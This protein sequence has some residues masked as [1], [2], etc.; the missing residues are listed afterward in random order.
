M[1]F[2]QV[3]YFLALCDVLNFTRAAEKCNVS[4][5]SLTRAIQNLEC[6]LGGPL[7]HRERQRT[8]LTELGRMMRP[9][10][11]QVHIQTQQA[12]SLAVRFTKLD[13]IP[14][15]VGVMCTI[16]PTVF[17]EF[18]RSFR[19]RHP[20]IDIHFLDASGY[21]LADMLL[22]GDVEVALYG[23]PE[24]LDERLHGLSLFRERFV[25]AFPSGHRFEAMNAVCA[26]ELNGERYVSRANCEVYQHAT[27]IFRQRGISTEMVLRSPREDWVQA[28]VLAGMGFGFFPEFGVT[29]QGLLTRPL[30]DPEMYRTINLVTVRGRPYSPAVGAFVREAKAY[31]W[32]ASAGVDGSPRAVA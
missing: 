16:G 14:L 21:A 19:E 23:L 6:E 17:C 13:D 9:Y 30:I 25:I 15:K 27:E 22:K 26:Q 18:L 28:L 1:E 31:C 5:P 10:L 4:Q 29:A 8:H 7:F 3:R 20:G 2:Y 24:E 32:P 12:K 11:E